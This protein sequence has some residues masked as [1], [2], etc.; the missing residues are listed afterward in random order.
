MKGLLCIIVGVFIGGFCLAQEPNRI[1]NRICIK[2]NP[3]ALIDVYGSF[4]YRLGAELKVYRN[5]AASFEL[6]KYFSVGENSQLEIRDHSSGWILRPEVKVYFN[7]QGLTSG[8]FISMEY[9]RKKITFNYTDSIQMGTASPYPQTYTIWKDISCITAKYG[10]LKV[11]KKGFVFEWF[12]GAGVRFC[13]GHNSLTPEE[14]A[15]VLTGENHGDLIGFGQRSI[16][17]VAPNFSIGFKLG[18]CFK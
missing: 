7:R 6:G 5:I 1:D 17:Y 10:N 2:V 11:Y 12:V 3:L 18:Y 16:N 14:N 8:R 13:S 15:G 4:S 9:I